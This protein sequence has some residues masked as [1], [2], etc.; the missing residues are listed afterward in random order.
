L[1]EAYNTRRYGVPLLAHIAQHSLRLALL[2][3]LNPLR[4]GA[5]QLA[6]GDAQPILLDGR[7]NIGK[8]AQRI[9]REVPAG[10]RG[11]CVLG[12]LAWIL[13]LFVPFL[14]V[15]ALV[16]LAIT[17]R[18]GVR[19]EARFQARQDAEYAQRRLENEI[20]ARHFG[21]ALAPGEVEAILAPYRA[22]VQDWV[23]KEIAAELP[24]L[25]YKLKRDLV[26][27][28]TNITAWLMGAWYVIVGGNPIGSFLFFV[29]WSSRAGEFFAAIMNVQ[30][31]LMRSRQSFRQLADLVGPEEDMAPA[32]ADGHR[33]PGS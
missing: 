20:L 11:L 18:M 31:E 5:G 30:Q 24:A 25:G 3:P 8:L 21:K 13:P 33:C 27:N 32:A 12:L 16:D 1:L 10:I 15:G 2:N 17:Y 29:A 22:A 28:L 9:A 6:T 7:E 26:F 19:L 23:Q 14:L 4:V